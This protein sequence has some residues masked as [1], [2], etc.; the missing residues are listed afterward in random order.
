MGA[1]SAQII[2]TVECAEGTWEADL[3][4]ARLCLVSWLHSATIRFLMTFSFDMSGEQ[5]LAF[6]WDA[7]TVYLP[8]RVKGH[9]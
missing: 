1:A 7:S 4:P 5:R 3:C 8:L 9:D 6:S 2:E